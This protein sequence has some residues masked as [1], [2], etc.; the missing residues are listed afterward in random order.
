MLNGYC[1]NRNYQP[2]QIKDMRPIA[3]MDT[4][5]LPVVQ[6]KSIG[7]HGGTSG[8]IWIIFSMSITPIPKIIEDR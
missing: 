7:N 5:Q 2:H 3:T 6:N 4:M 1:K 8:G